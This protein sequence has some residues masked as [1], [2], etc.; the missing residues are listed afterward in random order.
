[1]IDALQLYDNENAFSNS[2]V[3]PGSPFGRTTLGV[4]VWA[5][6]LERVDSFGNAVMAIYRLGDLA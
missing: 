4:A 2:K 1:L 5:C 3:E 6:A